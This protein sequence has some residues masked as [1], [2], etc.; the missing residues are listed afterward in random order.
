MHFVSA[1][2]PCCGVRMYPTAFIEFEVTLPSFCRAI[3]INAMLPYLLTLRDASFRCCLTD[4][5]LVF[6]NAH[7]AFQ[8][9]GPP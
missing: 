8:I 3:Y 4:Q 1:L 2:T 9:A 7:L 5:A 6:D